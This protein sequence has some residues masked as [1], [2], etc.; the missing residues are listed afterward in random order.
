MELARNDQNRTSS[1]LEIPTADAILAS[2]VIGSAATP[3]A[4]GVPPA[5]L[6]PT[7]AVTNNAP[8]PGEAVAAAAPAST[9]ISPQFVPDCYVRLNS[10]FQLYSNYDNTSLFGLAD[11]L[12]VGD[13]VVDG[14]GVV[15][16]DTFPCQ[17]EVIL[18]ERRPLAKVH[19]Q[20]C[21]NWCRTLC[22][23]SGL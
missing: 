11:I 2:R 14:T 23:W 3:E 21:L 17:L 20:L 8:D 16:T 13:L 10:G 19:M 18:S 12:I 22:A 4:S 6:V 5:E 9:G 1:I 15:A 7:G